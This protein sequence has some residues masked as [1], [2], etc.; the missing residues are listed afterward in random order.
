MVRLFNN[1]VKVNGESE[2]HDNEV[3]FSDSPSE[4]NGNEDAN[5]DAGGDPSALGEAKMSSDIGQD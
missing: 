3:Q 4:V 1:D 5:S 2:W